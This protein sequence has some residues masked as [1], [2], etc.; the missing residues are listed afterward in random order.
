MTI[1]LAFALSIDAFGMGLSYGLRRIRLNL[2]A[3]A[4]LF[5]VSMLVMALAVLFG[6]LIASFFDYHIAE[7]IASCWIILI[8]TW[9]LI[10]A[11]GKDKNEADIP[12]KITKLAAVQ[13]ALVL[14]VDSIAAG[15]AAAPLGL[16]IYI[17][18]ILTAAFQIAFLAL[19]VKL[20]AIL[21]QKYAK[22]RLWTMLAGIILILIGIIN[23]VI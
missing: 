21:S 12:K 5:A 22:K 8:G 13:L 2:W 20:A 23:L 17:L 4:V 16:T 9:T 14:S 19:G 11:F 6:N 1:F 7:I 15:I 10:S 18:P 3:Y